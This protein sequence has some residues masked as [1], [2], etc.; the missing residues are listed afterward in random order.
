MYITLH[1][2]DHSMLDV[3]KICHCH[4]IPNQ[5]K[6]K[7]CSTMDNNGEIVSASCGCPGFMEVTSSGVLFFPECKLQYQGV[8]C[9]RVP[10]SCRSGISHAREGHVQLMVFPL[11]SMNTEVAPSVS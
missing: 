2:H 7:T 11:S 3:C 4:K 5:E 10:P 6:E 1:S 9:N 8:K